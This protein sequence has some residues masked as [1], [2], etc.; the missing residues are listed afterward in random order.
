MVSLDG[1]ETL[2]SCVYVCSMSRSV[3]DMVWVTLISIMG[4]DN[5]YN[6]L[7]N[8]VIYGPFGYLEK[9]NLFINLLTYYLTHAMVIY[10]NFGILLL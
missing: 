5:M 3:R 8:T 2:T 10:L 9:V 6:L 4:D 7:F 1:W